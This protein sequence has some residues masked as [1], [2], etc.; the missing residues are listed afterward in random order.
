MVKGWQEEGRASRGEGQQ[1]QV[2]RLVLN[3]FR[4]TASA[5]LRQWVGGRGSEGEEFRE[6]ERARLFRAL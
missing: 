6:V 4:V 5:D 2:R 3:V 1:P